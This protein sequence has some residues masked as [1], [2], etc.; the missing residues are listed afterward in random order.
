MFLDPFLKSRPPGFQNH[1]SSSPAFF[2]IYV[3]T[4]SMTAEIHHQKHLVVPG[5][6]VI[7]PK[8]CQAILSNSKKQG[9]EG[10][11]F[12]LLPPSAESWPTSEATVFKA[13]K[14]LMTLAELLEE[15]LR[16]GK[17]MELCRHLARALFS[18]SKDSASQNQTMP[19]PSV[20]EM[21]TAK[22]KDECERQLYEPLK[23]GKLLK[24]ISTEMSIRQMQRHFLKR[25]G[26]S[27]KA[28]VTQKKTEASK[29]WLARK[30]IPIATIA[31]E[32]GYAN[33]QHFS[34]SFRN[35]AGLTPTEWRAKKS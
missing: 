1:L 11:S 22:I 2:W 20:A 7:L 24:N 14:T 15:S 17:P 9:Y 23:I 33:S 21:L 29:A 35:T 34:T 12:T 13:N 32:L 18:E 10:V 30:D 25:E 6:V 8:G 4:G 16:S 27:I 26:L 3:R 28:W 31:R 5:H 19:L